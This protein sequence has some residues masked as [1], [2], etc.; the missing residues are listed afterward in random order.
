MTVWL[1]TQLP[2]LARTWIAEALGMRTSKVRVIVPDVGGSFGSKWHLYPED[3]AVAA[4]AR[5]TGKPVRWIEDRYEHFVS[6]VHAREQ[7]TI[8]SLDSDEQ[9]C[10]R[11]IRSRAVADQGA[12]FHT[13]GPAPSANSSATSRRSPPTIRTAE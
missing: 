1:P 12:Y 7:R 11:G 9:G 2:S 13:A 3:L 10:L 6:T 8:I 5:A 4:M